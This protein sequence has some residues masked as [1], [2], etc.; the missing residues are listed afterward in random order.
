MTEAKVKICHLPKARGSLVIHF[1]SVEQALAASAS[2]LAHKPAAHEI[3]DRL[4]LGLAKENL[5]ARRWMTSFME[6]DPDATLQVVFFGENTG[7]VRE[8]VEGLL[9]ELEHKE[10]G[11]AHVP[12]LDTAGQTAVSNVRKAGLGFLLGVKGDKKPH[13]FIEDC[14]VSPENLLSYY[15]KLEQIIRT[16]D[17]QGSYYGHSSVGL[18]HIR[19]SINLKIESEVKKMVSIQNQTADLVLEF[20]GAMSGEHGDG[21][22]RSH[23]VPKFFGPM[24]Y[25]AFCEIK[26][27]FDPEGLMN[28]GKIVSI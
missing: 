13:A 4:L 18:M 19:P 22:A 17:T 27:A 3:M 1:N 9:S 20:G 2:I 15:Q 21:L 10:I 12:L 8:K 25:R 5:E 24:L 16:H 11:Y 26:R 23:L 28:P 6:G 7:N 14:A